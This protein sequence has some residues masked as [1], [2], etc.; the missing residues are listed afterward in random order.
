MLMRAGRAWDNEDSEGENG[1]DSC[2]VLVGALA[3]SFFFFVFRADSSISAGEE[4]M[5][6]II[7]KMVLLIFHSSVILSF[8]VEGASVVPR[9]LGFPDNLKRHPKGVHL[10]P[11]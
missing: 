3:N 2:F 7:C 4:G 9:V 11:Y 6:R 8:M 1:R 10:H 5:R